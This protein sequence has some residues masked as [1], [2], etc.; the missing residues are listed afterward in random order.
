MFNVSGCSYSSPI[1]NT[2]SPLNL[3]IKFNKVYS[4]KKNISNLLIK[5]ISQQMIEEWEK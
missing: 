2:L 3:Q 1:L 5:N 4:W